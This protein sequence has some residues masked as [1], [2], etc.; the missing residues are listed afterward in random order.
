[1][2]VYLFFMQT[3]DEEPTCHHGAEPTTFLLSSSGP[4]RTILS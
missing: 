2:A 3:P 4:S 1:M